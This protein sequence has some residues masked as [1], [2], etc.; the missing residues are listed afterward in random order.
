MAW[1]EVET[2]LHA[3]LPEA[4]SFWASIIMRV[5]SVGEAVEGETP[6]WVR[7]EVAEAMVFWTVIK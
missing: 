3:S 2:L 6:K 1:R 4:Y 5:E 7:K